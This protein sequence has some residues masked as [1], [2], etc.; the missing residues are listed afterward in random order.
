MIIASTHVTVKGSN[1]DLFRFLLLFEAKMKELSI[2]DLNDVVFERENLA[3]KESTTFEFGLPLDNMVEGA[4]DVDF[5]SLILSVVKKFP[6]L[7][8]SAS[9]E[10]E[11]PGDSHYIKIFISNNVANVIMH[12]W[13]A[14]WEE[15]WDNFEGDCEEDED[16]GVTTEETYKLI[17]NIW[18]KC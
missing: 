5:E 7:E 13:D 2:D 11:G 9:I 15:E 8:V 17:N 1:K 14:D 18:K 4:E 6:A 3:D 12:D 10:W 16:E